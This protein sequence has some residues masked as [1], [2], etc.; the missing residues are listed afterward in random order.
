MFLLSHHSISLNE[1][2][3]ASSDLRVGNYFALLHVRSQHTG[4]G[5]PRAVQLEAAVRGHLRRET[6]HLGRATAGKAG[7]GPHSLAAC[8]MLGDGVQGTSVF[9]ISTTCKGMHY[10]QGIIAMKNQ[11]VLNKTDTEMVVLFANQIWM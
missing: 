11:S 9:T 8:R 6:L 5:S 4:H 1:M 7:D 10:M 2:G 3:R